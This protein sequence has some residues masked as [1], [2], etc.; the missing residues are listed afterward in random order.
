MKIYEGRDGSGPLHV[1]TIYQD[2]GNAERP[3]LRVAVWVRGP[4]P[5]W[6]Q[7]DEA[8]ALALSRTRACSPSLSLADRAGSLGQV[9]C[10]CCC[11]PGR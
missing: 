7:Q 8:E 4:R 6:Q 9:C 3:Q 1:V 2:R 10:C 11:R 5:S